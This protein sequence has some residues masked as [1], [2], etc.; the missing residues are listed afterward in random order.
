MEE[1]G[2]LDVGGVVDHSRGG[3]GGG[4]DEDGAEEEDREDEDGLTM[5]VVA[6][7]GCSAGM[8]V[9]IFSVVPVRM[10]LPEIPF[11]SRISSMVVSYL[12]ERLQSES[13]GTTSCSTTRDRSGRRGRCEVE[14]WGEDRGE[15]DR[16]DSGSGACR[17]G[18][19]A[20]S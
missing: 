4:L 11:A 9:G 15:D 5:E 16:E 12:R 20:V 8:F 7:E 13:P 10:M 17:M 6:E 18:A 1:E 3:A 19:W 2:V 14:D